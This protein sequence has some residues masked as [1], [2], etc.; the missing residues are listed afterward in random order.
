MLQN[1]MSS[2]GKLPDGSWGVLMSSSTRLARDL[3]LYCFN[4][5]INSSFHIEISPQL[6]QCIPVKEFV[7]PVQ[8]PIYNDDKISLPPPALRQGH[9]NLANIEFK[10][11]PE[12]PT[13]VTQ[14]QA[15]SS[16]FYTPLTSAKSTRV[17]DEDEDELD[18]SSVPKCDLKGDGFFVEHE[19]DT[20]LDEL[21]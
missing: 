17:K 6:S 7:A 1:T 16:I 9:T 21:D 5:V 14:H 4:N 8:E 11:P 15:T 10:T 3:L 20:F 19:T 12:S 13:R 2:L 18:L